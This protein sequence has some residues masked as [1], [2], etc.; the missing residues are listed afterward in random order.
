ERNPGIAHSIPIW[1][2]ARATTAAPSYFDP[3]E[4]SNRKF[5]DGGFGTNNPAAEMFWEVA[6]MNGGDPKS[7]SLLLSI[8]T[9]ESK[10]NRFKDGPVGKYRGYLNAARRLASSSA[11]VHENLQALGKAFGIPYYRFN[12]PGGLG[13]MKLDEWKPRRGRKEGTLE[14]ICSL[15]E[16]YCNQSDVR[17]QL[18]KV[19]QILVEHRKDRAKSD[20]WGLVSKG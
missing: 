14:K 15:T 2:A 17:K 13:K 19:A 7:V 10:I 12:V 16:N 3:I 8:G 5:G 11:A 9:G 4:I 6:N 20:M 18:V 1:E